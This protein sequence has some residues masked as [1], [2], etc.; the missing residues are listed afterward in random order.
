MRLDFLKSLLRSPSPQFTPNNI[1]V[2][3]QCQ[4]H[5]ELVHAII[6]MLSLYKAQWIFSTIFVS[7]R[8]IK[9]SFYE[10][11]KWYFAGANWW[12]GIKTDQFR[13]RKQRKRSVL[14]P[15][16]QLARAKYQ[17]CD[18]WNERLMFRR[19]TKN[20]EKIHCALVRKKC[21]RES[22]VSFTHFF[23]IFYL[24]LE[25]YHITSWL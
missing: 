15:N 22:F 16:H 21:P 9:R 10:S 11:Q 20:V 14:M 19:E 25:C 4:S 12:F 24:F 17:F 1:T 13:Q 8:N 18:S 3:C 6:R 5:L 23:Y 7:L 2:M